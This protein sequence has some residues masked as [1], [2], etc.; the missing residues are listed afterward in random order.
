MFG[1]NANTHCNKRE[2]PN[3]RPEWC[4]K[5]RPEWLH[6]WRPE[7]RPEKR[8]EEREDSPDSAIFEIFMFLIKDNKN[9][10]GSLV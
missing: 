2:S 4:P 3:W 6:K 8:P 10:S 7:W 9:T 5:C 1:Y